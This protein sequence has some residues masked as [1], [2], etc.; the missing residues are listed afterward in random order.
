MI[1]VTCFQKVRQKKK[2]PSELEKEGRYV[3]KYDKGF[4]N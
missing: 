1:I 4:L 3:N 2:M